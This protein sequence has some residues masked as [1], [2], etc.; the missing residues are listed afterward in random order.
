[1]PPGGDYFIYSN[2]TAAQYI[3]IDIAKINN[4]SNKLFAIF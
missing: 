3:F 2:K 4:F 1:M